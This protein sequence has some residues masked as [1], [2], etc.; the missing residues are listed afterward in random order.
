VTLQSSFLCALQFDEFRR[1]DLT[2]LERYVTTI[3]DSIVVTAL[4]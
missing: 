4:R 1:V 2:A 3:S